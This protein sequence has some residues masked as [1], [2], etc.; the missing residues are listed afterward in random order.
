[1]DKTEQRF[2]NRLV[3]MYGVDSA[4]IFFKQKLGKDAPDDI[5]DGIEPAFNLNLL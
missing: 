5:D 1:M 3:K 4:R 2:L